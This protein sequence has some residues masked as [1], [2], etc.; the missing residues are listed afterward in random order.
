MLNIYVMMKKNN[1]IITYKQNKY[2][3]WDQFF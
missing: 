3:I 2:K 1:H